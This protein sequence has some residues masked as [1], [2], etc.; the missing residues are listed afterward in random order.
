[1]KKILYI[2][3]LYLIFFS[4]NIFSQDNLMQNTA[5]KENYPVGIGP[6]FSFK[7]GVNGNYT[8]D[9]RQNRASFNGIP[10]FGINS[11]FPLSQTSLLGVSIDLAYS[12]YSFTFK[13]FHT[14]DKY[15]QS[16]SYVTIN[17]MFHFYQFQ[18]GLNFGVPVKSD[19]SETVSTSKIR[20]ISEIRVGFTYPL[21]SYDEGRLSSFI[22]AGYML[23]GLYYDYGRDDPLK[24]KIPA[25]PPQEIS[26]KYN[27]RTISCSIGLIYHFNI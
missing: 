8:L 3:I 13:N 9:G 18:I 19:I 14:S 2:F 5:Q 6:F 1:M 26:N 24:E 22:Q 16:T 11:Y 17:P 15:T 21:L 27:P 20:A 7:A 12:T 4:I 25:V 10:D 23:S